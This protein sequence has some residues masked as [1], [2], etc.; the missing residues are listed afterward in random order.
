VL[1][2]ADAGTQ[3]RFEGGLS[4]AQFNHRNFIVVHS[5]ARNLLRPDWMHSG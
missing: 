1:V 4:R 3:V 2:L 5:T